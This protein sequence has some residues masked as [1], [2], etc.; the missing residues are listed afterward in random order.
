VQYF[1][2]FSFTFGFFNNAEYREWLIESG[3][4]PLRVELIPKDMIYSSRQDLAAWIRTTWLPRQARLPKSK[5]SGFIEAIMDE[6]LKNYPVDHDG[7]I[8]ISM[9]RLEVEAK[10]LS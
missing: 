8:H 7:A 10:K 2:G 6:Y 4:E 9:V 3:F 1:R 5:R